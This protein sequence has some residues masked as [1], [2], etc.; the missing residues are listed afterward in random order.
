MLSVNPAPRQYAGIVSRHAARLLLLTVLLA[1]AAR[2]QT[3]TSTTSVT[4][5]RTPSGLQP[6]SPAGSYELSGFDNV[7][8]YNGNLSFHLPLLRVGGRGSAGYAMMLA[9]NLKSWHV[10]HTHKVMPDG[11][12]VDSYAPTQ[13]GW[14]PYGGYGAGQLSGRSYGLQTSSNF[15]CGRYY[16]KALARLTFSAADGTE[17][18]LRDKDAN[19][20][21]TGGE[22]LDSI[23]CTQGASR[24]TVFI[25]A[26]GTS[27]TFISDVEIRDITTIN[28][29]GPTGFSVSGYLMLRDGTRYRIDGGNVTWIRDRNGNQVSF[30]YDTS[31]R[32][33]SVTDSLNRTVTINYNVSDASPFG[34]CDQII[35]KG[36]GGAQRIVRVSHTDLGSALRPNSGYALRYPGGANGLFPELSGSSDTLYDPTVASAVWLPD[37][38]VNHRAYH[39]YY[40]PYGELA[41]VELPTGGAVEYD[42]TAGSGVAYACPTCNQPGDDKEIYRRV[43]A[44]RV[45]PDGS[46]G[47]SFEH[48]DIYTNAEAVGTPSST[49]TVEQFNQANT[50]RARSR[51]YFDGSALDSMFGG[52]VSYPY[53]A[54]YEG[55]ERQTDQLDT[56][57]GIDAATV[58]HSVAYTRAQRT[59][60]QWWSS[61]AAANHLD[62]SKEPPNDPRLLTTVTTVEPGGA[63]LVSEQTA[64]NPVDGSVGFDQY[65]NPTDTWEYDYGTTPGAVGAFIRRTHIDYV[66]DA[67]YVN[68]NTNPALGAS[69]RSL[70]SQQWVSTDIAGNNKASLT[71]YGYDESGLTDCPNIIRHDAAFTTTFK[72]RGNVTSVTRYANANAGTGA[73]TSRSSYDIAGNVV[74]APGPLG[75]TATT[76]YNDDASAFCNDNVRCAGTFAANIYAF[77]K[78]VTSSVPDASALYGYAAGTFGSATAF[79]TSTIYDYY[80][81][82]TYSATDAN[83][84]TTTLSYKVAL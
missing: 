76:S 16:S 27:A 38:G 69:L 63:N 59:P 4:D 56:A 19:G 81:G 14:V 70:P 45:Y 29:L 1:G 40:N 55:N 33:I 51:H 30:G 82:L 6:G 5:G 34:L 20:T 35:F 52:D 53:G 54:W 62:A 65:N 36:F 83:G 71:V 49:V 79:T 10:K 64:V 60:V 25:T 39:L 58:L 8:L 84:Q 23:S 12:E 22:P 15:S 78:G 26:D 77:P 74:G 17:Y 57:G 31:G 32:V 3:T 18:E 7:N 37:D 42:M 67:P 2:A 46:T 72:T 75:N 28:P 48:K 44:R 41:R 80:T 73:V 13:T 21:G 50:P 47:S 68:A 43:V 9:L 24:G 66:P 11:S 61:Y